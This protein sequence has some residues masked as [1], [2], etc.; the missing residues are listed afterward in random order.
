[1][2]CLFVNVALNVTLTLQKIGRFGPRGNRGPSEPVTTGSRIPGGSYFSRF[3]KFLPGSHWNHSRVREMLQGRTLH[4]SP[5]PFSL[6]LSCSFMADLSPSHFISFEYH[7]SK[8]KRWTFVRGDT[9]LLPDSSLMNDSSLE[10]T[11]ALAARCSLSFLMLLLLM[12]PVQ[13]H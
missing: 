10:F 9:Q 4:P 11:G 1:M 8:A 5:S 2:K 6:F 12:A 7:Q 13:W 3:L